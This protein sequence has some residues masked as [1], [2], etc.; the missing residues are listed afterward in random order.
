MAM[1]LLPE[2]CFYVV[3][4]QSD[5]QVISGKR[6]ESERESLHSLLLSI[7]GG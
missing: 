6:R 5:L 7:N 2:K 4:M 3:I 1:T